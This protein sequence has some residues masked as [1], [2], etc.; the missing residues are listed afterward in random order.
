[1]RKSVLMLMSLFIALTVYAQ[2]KVKHVVLIGCDGFGAYALPEA[3]MPNLK[4]LMKDGSWS[5]KARS[6]L[7]SSSAVNWASMIMG[8]GPTLHGYT[9]W[10]SAVPEIPSS[11]LTKEGM[12]PSIFSILKEQ[13]PSLITALIYSWQGIDPLVQK[14]TTDIRI[15]AKDNDDFCTE[16][17]VE[18]IKTKK[19]TLTFI[20]LD[21]PDG[22]GHNTGHRT[23]AYYEELKKVDVRIGKIVQAVKDAGIANETVII[24]TADHGGKDK[25]HGG[26]T[27]DEVLIPWVV[28]GKGVK[29][30]Q[31]L[32]NTIITYDTGAT[33][34][35]LL[36]LKV[37]E[38]WR[39]L[40]VKQ[41]FLT[42]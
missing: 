10:N 8:A 20:H 16:S 5:L 18:V 30:N 29:K 11:D 33:I 32:K 7:P 6:V 35:W 27:L 12:F 34:A 9:E 41:A 17:A 21:Q 3:D 1:M 38:S 26:K 39:G 19:P 36:G 37:P 14:G 24:V 31:E 23:P 15:P 42:K 28:Y 22:V 2:Q 40:P 4:N 13:K 25:G